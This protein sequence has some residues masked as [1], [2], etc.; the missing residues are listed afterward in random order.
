MS[1]ELSA[2]QT[3]AETETTH[4]ASDTNTPEPEENL[5][6]EGVTSPDDQPG[7]GE[8][9]GEAESVEEIEFDFGGNKKKWAKGTPIDQIAD[10][11]SQFTK[12]TW[13]DYT[14]KSQEVA[15][16]RKALETREKVV[17]KLQTLNG[18]ALE[19]FSRGKAVRHELEQLQKIDIN[20]LWQSNP[21]QAR[22][23]S[24]AI[25][26]K[27]AEFNSIVNKVSTL[28]GE[29]TRAQQTEF[30]RRIEEGKAAVEKRVPGFATKHLAEVIEYVVKEHGY[31][32]EVAER[33]WPKDPAGAVMA[34]KAMLYDRM[35]AQA[36]QA[37]RAPKPQQQATP[38]TPP[39]AG[40]GG[41][42]Q[43]QPNDMSVSELAKHLGL[44]G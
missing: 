42:A 3:G 11:I 20:A 30:A 2:A 36:K 6:P 22:R 9:E 15:E 29:L 40:R 12:G 27:T 23:V 16:Q 21:D 26:A 37:A 13:S 44:R 33:D 5:D 39:K 35:Q 8:A 4:A 7:E 10:E 1:D 17:E 32:K 25:S 38:I 19:E 34:Y 14:R 43:K 24:D 18:Q 41:T 28:E 31:P